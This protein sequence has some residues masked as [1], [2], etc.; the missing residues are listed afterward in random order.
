MIGN[1][2]DYRKF[3]KYVTCKL[4]FAP[5]KK[6]IFMYKLLMVLVVFSQVSLIA[7]D[8]EIARGGERGG[9]R[10]GERGGEFHHEGN[11]HHEENFRRDDFKHDN[12]NENN[13]RREGDWNRGGNWNEGGTIIVPEVNQPVNPL[14]QEDPNYP[15]NQG[16]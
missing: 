14:Y 15:Y 6:G 11:F 8:D 2:K 12:F 9:S 16:Y 10:G 1:S 5:I 4:Y 3:K 13:F 7:S